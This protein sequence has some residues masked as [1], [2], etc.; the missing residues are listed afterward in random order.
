MAL[1]L[2][3][4]ALLL[5]SWGS[6]DPPAGPAPRFPAPRSPALTGDLR[7]VSTLTGSAP[8][9]DSAVSQAK[10]VFS[11]LRAFRLNMPFCRFHFPSEIPY[12]FT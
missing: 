4:L 11:L 12:L 1:G 2:T 5:S 8:S 10:S 9:P 6:G 7:P 3:S